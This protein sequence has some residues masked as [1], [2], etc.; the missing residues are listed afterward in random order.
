MVDFAII[1]FPKCGTTSMI[2]NLTKCSSLYIVPKE[3]SL[4]LL[5]EMKLPENKKNG[6]KHPSAIYNLSSWNE[7]LQHKKIIICWRDPIEHLISFY[8]Y[9]K[10][11]I[12]LNAKWVREMRNANPTCRFQYTFEDVLNGMDFFDCSLAKSRMDVYT[13]EV[14]KRYPLSKILIIHFDELKENPRLFYSKICYFVGID[15]SELP[16]DFE[17]A[18]QNSD[19]IDMNLTPEQQEFLHN[20]YKDTTKNMSYF[21]R[22][23]QRQL[24]MKLKKK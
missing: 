9:R 8:Q 3:P 6:F 14:M 13:Y 17:V 16:T 24:L 18:N 2:F 22:L 20:Y 21:T 4:Q 5:T 15:P 7:L 1:G 19:K 12:E 23:T 10:K 11:E